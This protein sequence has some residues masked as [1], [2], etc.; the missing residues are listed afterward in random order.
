MD[1]PTALDGASLPSHQ[2][3]TISNLKQQ[4][5]PG[6]SEFGVECEDTSSHANLD[7]VSV[8]QVSISQS[9][10]EMPREQNQFAKQFGAPSGLYHAG[11]PM[12]S[13][14]GAGATIGANQVPSNSMSFSGGLKF[15]Q[16]IQRPAEAPIGGPAS[17]VNVDHASDNL[18]MVSKSDAGHGLF[19]MDM[20][21]D[22]LSGVG[23]GAKPIGTPSS[24]FAMGAA[25]GMGTAN[26]N[27]TMTNN[28]T[29]MSDNEAF[30]A[31]MSKAEVGDD[32]DED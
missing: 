32:D 1:V 14:F 7:N 2:S 23:E 24:S 9:Q 10:S 25:M 21:N 29:K 19:K 11:Y 12:A 13:S 20:G 26:A 30:M 5:D 28:E 27:I 8:S 18:T 17:M 16:G 3:S 15:S 4:V 31:Y 22:S 6:M